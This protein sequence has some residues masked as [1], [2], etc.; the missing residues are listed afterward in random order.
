M[1]NSCGRCPQVDCMCYHSPDIL[2]KSYWTDRDALLR[3][4]FGC[5]LSRSAWSPH[6]WSF[7]F[8]WQYYSRRTSSWTKPTTSLSLPMVFISYRHCLAASLYP[9]ICFRGGM[10]L[11]G[12]R[13]SGH[14]SRREAPSEGGAWE[15]VSPSP[16]WGPRGVTARENFETWGAIWCNLV[17]FGNKLAVLLFAIFVNENIAIM[18]DMQWT[19]QLIVIRVALAVP[20]SAYMLASL[21]TTEDVKKVLVVIL[22]WMMWLDAT[23]LSISLH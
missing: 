21:L 14:E 7:S 8:H 16:V 19:S 23:A 18:L 11:S 17:H 22:C 1:G 20:T 6:C 15:G 13:S 5:Q 9:D 12:G 3:I 4:C 2:D 10:K